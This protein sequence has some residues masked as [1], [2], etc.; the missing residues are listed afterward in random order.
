MTSLVQASMEDETK[1]AETI[2]ELTT[3]L[4]V[5]IQ[6]CKQE[7]FDEFMLSEESLTL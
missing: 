1:V 6:Y 7:G 3:K 2:Y 5:L 4:G